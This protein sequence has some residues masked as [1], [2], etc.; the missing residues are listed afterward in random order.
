M[1]KL[2]FKLAVIIGLWLEDTKV[3]SLVTEDIV[4]TG[5]CISKNTNLFPPTEVPTAEVLKT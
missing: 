1:D 2:P 3:I 4:L 5:P